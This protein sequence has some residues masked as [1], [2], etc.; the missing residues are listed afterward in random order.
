M[1]IARC[2]QE[3][4][5][6]FRIDTHDLGFI[7]VPALKRDWGLLGNN[8]TEKILLIILDCGPILIANWF[9]NLGMVDLIK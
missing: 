7:M 5:M 4:S 9:N 8:K 6:A 2:V 3:I 1:G